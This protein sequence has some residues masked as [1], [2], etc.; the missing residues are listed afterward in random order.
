M[1]RCGD[2]AVSVCSSSIPVLSPSCAPS[3][4]APSATACN[5]GFRKALRE[6][7]RERIALLRCALV[8]ACVAAASLVKSQVVVLCGCGEL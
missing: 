4:T 2:A 7:T 8:N 1:S 6:A 3:A 5:V